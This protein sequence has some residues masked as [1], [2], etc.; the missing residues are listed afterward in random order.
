[1]GLALH[2]SS[3]IGVRNSTCTKGIYTLNC[4]EIALTPHCSSLELMDSE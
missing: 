4:C 3:A 1:M 2:V